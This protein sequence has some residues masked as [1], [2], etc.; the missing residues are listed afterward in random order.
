[1]APPQGSAP[2][3]AAPGTANKGRLVTIMAHMAGQC[4]EGTGREFPGVEALIEAAE[5]LGP[6]GPGGPRIGDPA[7]LDEAVGGE[8]NRRRRRPAFVAYEVLI[9]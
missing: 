7:P 2:P 1:M 8:R 3:W 9:F 5:A 4:S 6:D